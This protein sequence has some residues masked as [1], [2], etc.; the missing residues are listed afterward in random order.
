[1]SSFCLPGTS[2][3]MSRL[4]RTLPNITQSDPT[5]C[6]LLSKWWKWLRAWPNTWVLKCTWTEKY[7]QKHLDLMYCVSWLC[8]PV[9]TQEA[10]AYCGLVTYVNTQK[11]LNSGNIVLDLIFFK[12]FLIQ[13]PVFKKE[14]SYKWLIAL[15]YLPQHTLLSPKCGLDFFP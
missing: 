15:L 13:L 9:N 8:W 5:Y 6:L 7:K 4:L 12:T 3:T 1:M 2:Y 10:S 11:V 14:V